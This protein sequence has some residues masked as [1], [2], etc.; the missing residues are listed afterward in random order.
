VHRSI[1]HN[2]DG[3]RQAANSNQAPFAAIT[4]ASGAKKYQG[5]VLTFLEPHIWDREAPKTPATDGFMRARLDQAL[6]R[7][8]NPDRTWRKLIC[9]SKLAAK[10]PRYIYLGTYELATEDNGDLMVGELPPM[11]P[12][13]NQGKYIVKTLMAKGLSREESL[14]WI[15]DP[16]NWRSTPLSFVEFDCELFAML[17]T[18]EGH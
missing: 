10:Q 9:F 5:C 15:D 3:R 18:M 7:C 14:E 8:R 2:P 11:E 13:S 6:A 12:D 16:K 17:K 1:V 4:A